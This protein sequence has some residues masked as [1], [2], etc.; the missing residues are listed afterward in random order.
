MTH[1][2]LTTALALLLCGGQTMA[3]QNEWENP[4]RY[5]WNREKGHADL[6]FYDSRTAAM[7]A[8]IDNSAFTRKLSGTWKFLFAPSIKESIADFYSEGIDDSEWSDIQVPSNWEIQ[9][10]GEAIIHNIQY[11]FTANPPY[12]DIDN[13]V[14]TYRTE[15][16]VPEEWS[17]HEVMLRFGSISGYARIYVNGRQVG[18]TKASKSPAEFNVT[19]F[20]RSG[21]NLLAVQVYRWSDAS[22]MEDQDFWRL[23][24]IERDVY[25]QAYPKLC[26]WDFFLHS[27][28]DSN[29]KNGLFR[30]EIDLRAFEGN[31]VS[32]G[33]VRV[34]LIDAAGKTVTSQQQ[35]FKISAGSDTVE[36]SATIK[37]VHQWNGEHPYLYTCL[38]SLLDEK[39]NQLAMTSYPIGFRTI[40]IKDSKLL[41]NGV[42]IYI[43]GVNRHEHN[44]STGHVQTR[45]MIIHDLKLM[46]QHNINA[47]RT[48]HY[49]NTEL[50]YRLCDEYGIYVVDEANIET[51][52]MGSVPYFKDTIPH[53][54][55]RSDW[56]DAH[57]DRISRLVAR[58]KN[59]A[60][61]IGWSLGNECGNGKVFHDM[62]QHLKQYDPSRFVQ[63]E[64]AWEDW[65]TDVVCPMYPYPSTMEKY[66]QSGK[67]RPFIM[68]EYAH[69][70]GNSTGN[71]QDLWNI[72]YKYPNLWG[73]FIWDFQDQGFKVKADKQDG[74]T[75][76]M[77]TGRLG[78]GRWIED[79]R[80]DAFTAE[81]GIIGADGTPKPAA[82]EVKR[83]YQNIRF[84]EAD[85]KKGQISIE[86]LFNFSNLN[87]YQMQWQVMK[88][89]VEVAQGPFS[90]DLKPHQQTTVSL[91][92][93][94]LV[95]SDGEYLL[96]LYAYTKQ[97]TD[98]LPSN[99]EI[100]KAQ[101]QLSETTFFDRDS[102]VSG[103]LK[104]ENKDNVLSFTSGKIS[105]KINLKTGMITDYALGDVHPIKSYPEPAFWRAAIDN[106]FGNKMPQ[107]CGAWRTAQVNRS[108]EK[109]TVNEQNEE[110]VE[111]TVDWRLTDIDVPY[112]MK[113]LVRRD[114]SIVVTGRI[115]M[116]GRKLPELPRFGMDMT[117]VQKFDS[118][119]YYGRGPQENYIDR[120]TAAH[121]GIYTDDVANQYYPYIRPQETGNKTDVRWLT[122]SNNDGVTLRITGLQPI[123]FSALHYPTDDLD[124]GL[125][126]KFLTTI[127]VVPQKLVFLHVD[128]KQRGV[129]GDNSWGMYPHNEYRL[130][131]KVYEY[132]YVMKLE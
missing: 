8:S 21:K 93:K 14:G 29:Y 111:V 52:G 54:A 102:L 112:T 70:M 122:L 12:I 117:L 47:I 65:N 131:D 7:T 81:D 74:R 126:R 56:Y 121:I 127:D 97:S 128:L 64:Q 46:K 9:G 34:E 78:S 86:N 115:D 51:H 87:E 79:N 53:P 35:D 110:G 57:V 62:Y 114:G 41:V 37:N 118:L 91:P 49:P 120:N 42:P 30:A 77:C 25:I 43:K 58:D 18:M 44:D 90:V 85:L 38:I 72:I 59:H 100:A 109:V 88:D 69:S 20:L 96:N 55:Y 6:S 82:S 32:N 130:L 101:M 50:F 73:G 16:S 108:V 4:T 99:F 24:G 76:W 106:D 119:S 48:C 107:R 63:F 28:L 89:G 5:E 67:T 1:N 129:G 84:A 75:Y 113:Y 98:L 116:T 2:L 124:A 39:G 22:Y 92:I 132:S 15:F 45:E 103:D 123:G 68:C 61:V 125:S 11:P 80:N 60:C 10:F 66:G 3:Q 104:Y 23:S 27:Q 40:E 17:N 95:A 31:N 36:V 26:V 13:P 83:V 19:K 94:N 33:K 105:G 71:L